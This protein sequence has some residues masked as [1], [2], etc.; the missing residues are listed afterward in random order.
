MYIIRNKGH[1]PEIY[2]FF[3]CRDCLQYV[4]PKFTCY[5]ISQFK[6]PRKKHDQYLTRHFKYI[7]ILCNYCPATKW[8][9]VSSNQ[10]LIPHTPSPHV[11]TCFHNW[12]P[13][14]AW[15]CWPPCQAYPKATSLQCRIVR[16]PPLW[17]VGYLVTNCL[18][19]SLVGQATFK[20][21]IMCMVY[22]RVIATEINDTF[23]KSNLDYWQLI[24]Y[25]DQ[26][27]YA[28]CKVH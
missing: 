4:Y 14:E 24:N 27:H 26:H 18:S 8:S 17:L 7:R 13:V 19:D 25:D 21:H 15:S 28:K 16:K 11:D 5:P 22:S 3:M 20:Q 12:L 23:Y 1:C 10:L 6:F 2:I 9:K